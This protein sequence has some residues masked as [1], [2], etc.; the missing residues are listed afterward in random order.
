[1]IVAS[2]LCRGGGAPLKI[3]PILGSNGFFE[4]LPKKDPAGV[5]LYSALFAFSTRVYPKDPRKPKKSALKNLRGAGEAEIGLVGPLLTF[6]S[7]ILGENEI[8]SPLSVF[9]ARF[10]GRWVS[11]CIGHATAAFGLLVHRFG[12]IS[13]GLHARPC[14]MRFLRIFLGILK[15]APQCGLLGPNTGGFAL[16]RV[17]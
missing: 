15:T 5:R 9:S 1:M 4:K 7:Y 10:R 8:T 3:P 11:G 13:V 17:P 12:M 16:D 14:I 6:F 2:G